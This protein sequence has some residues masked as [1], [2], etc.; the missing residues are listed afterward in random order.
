MPVGRAVAEFLTNKA[1]NID[2]K[3]LICSGACLN[4]SG[5]WASA[6]RSPWAGEIS[7][8]E[9]VPVTLLAADFQIEIVGTCP[10]SSIPG[11]HEARQESAPKSPKPFRNWGIFGGLPCDRPLGTGGIRL[12]PP[13][14]LRAYRLELVVRRTLPRYRWEF[15]FA[16]T[17]F[18]MA[19]SSDR[20][21]G[22]RAART[23]RYVVSSAVSR[24]F[25]V[26]AE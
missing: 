8:E 20:S 18:W 15:T 4:I 1:H 6:A 22:P 24:S 19:S 17:A 5:I 3:W 13:A 14:V 9:A 26:V 12:R 21:F 2:N 11:E 23:V 16:S 25:S 10:L 7:E